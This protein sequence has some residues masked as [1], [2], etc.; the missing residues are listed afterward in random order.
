MFH[1][2]DALTGFGR[3]GSSS[4]CLAVAA[5][6]HVYLD[7]GLSS[8]LPTDAK[9]DVRML[10]VMAEVPRGTEVQQVKSHLLCDAYSV[11]L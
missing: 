1:Q 4:C 3:Q 7:V 6:K 10:T 5:G 11:W 8:C 2:L 9:D